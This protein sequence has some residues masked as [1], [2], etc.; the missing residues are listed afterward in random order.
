MHV[1]GGKVRVKS[2]LAQNGRAH[3]PSHASDHKRNQK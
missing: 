2:A 1:S 3:V